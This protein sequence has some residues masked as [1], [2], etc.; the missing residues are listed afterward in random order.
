MVTNLESDSI[1]DDHGFTKHIG[2]ILGIGQLGI[3][4]KPE[5]RIVVYFLV[6]QHNEFSTFISYK[7]NHRLNNPLAGIFLLTII[8]TSIC[9]H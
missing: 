1:V 7:K 8:L 5:V 4:I 6:S 2:R 3:K 9:M